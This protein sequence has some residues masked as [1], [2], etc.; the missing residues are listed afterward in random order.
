MESSPNQRQHRK[1]K[2]ASPS[3]HMHMTVATKLLSGKAS[4]SILELHE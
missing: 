1:K 4:F 3:T 2:L